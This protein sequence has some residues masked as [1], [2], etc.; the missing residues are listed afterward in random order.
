[1]NAFIQITRF[2]YEEPYHLQLLVR[3]S[4]GHQQGEL[5]IYC[6]ADDLV[7]FSRELSGFPREKNN[8]AL[9]ELGSEDPKARFAFYFGIRAVRLSAGGRCAIEL[10]FCN[11]LEPPLRALTEFSIE[12]LPADIDRLAGLLEHFSRLSHTVLDWRVTD[13]ALS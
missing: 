11:N 13:G 10:R 8:S 5:E 1:M 2:P 9:W 6:N 3:A 7:A 12:A 4:N